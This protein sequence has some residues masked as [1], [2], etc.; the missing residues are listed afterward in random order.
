MKLDKVC[1]WCVAI[2]SLLYLN[3]FLVNK[4][5]ISLIHKSWTEK[6]LVYKTHLFLRTELFHLISYK[7]INNRCIYLT[8]CNYCFTFKNNTKRNSCI[9]F[10]L[11]S[12]LRCRNIHKYNSISVFKAYTRTFF[13]I[14]CRWDILRFYFKAFCYLLKLLA[15]RIYHINPA[16]ILNI[17]QCI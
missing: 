4:A 16:S 12:Y 6:H 8:H 1:I 11:M 9:H 15:C 2:N 14:K 7:I 17:C 5:K 13:F 3:S 10:F